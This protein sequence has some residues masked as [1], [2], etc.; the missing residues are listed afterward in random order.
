MYV[1]CDG[2][3]SSKQAENR[4]V[5]A[6]Y[7]FVTKTIEHKSNI[8]IPYNLY[9]SH[10]TAFN[11]LGADRNFYLEDDVVI[12][13]YCY[14]VFNRALD[15]AKIADPRIAVVNSS[16]LCQMTRGDKLEHWREFTNMWASLCQYVVTREGWNAV[17]PNYEEYLYTF[18]PVHNY[19]SIN[20]EKVAAWKDK[21]LRESTTLYNVG[22]KYLD[23]HGSACDFIF[24][25]CLSL[26][27]YYYITSRV[28]R[29]LHIG[30][31]GEHLYPELHKAMGLSCTEM[32]VI[33]EDAVNEHFILEWCRAN[34]F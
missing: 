4:K 17:R 30:E 11:D 21:K 9:V 2:G 26:A 6:R 33:E 1:Y 34:Y 19:D 7:P 29:V 24:G 12:S 5:I 23:R 28:N 15:W 18:V 13:P 27:G 3:V 25:V 8:G 31:H 20:V 14:R 16:I 22:R 32:D 10:Q